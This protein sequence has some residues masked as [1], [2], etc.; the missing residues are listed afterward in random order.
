[1]ADNKGIL[2]ENTLNASL[3]KAGVQS[4]TFVGAGSDSNAPDAQ[5]TYKGKDYKVEVKLDMNVDFGQGSLDYDL[6]NE[7]WIIG[8]G[9]TESGKQMKQ[10]L[11]KIGVDKLVNKK[12][13]PKGAPRR[14]SVPLSQ[15][16]KDDVDYDYKTFKNEFVDI[17]GDAVANYY[18]SK[19]TYYIQ[20]G[21]KGLYYMGKDIAKLGVP[22]FDLKLKLRIRLK[23]G[24]SVPI[25]NYRFATAIQAVK[26]TLS[27]SD[28]DLDNMDY[29]KALAARGKK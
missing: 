8:G 15:Y 7:K 4:K 20:I 28:A 24:G 6:E 21:G 12:W 27:N 19:Q 11:E 10:F 25:Y 9:K 29:L 23:R 14:Y 5:I 3:K 1:M 17:P 16:K 22:E 26:G 13:G 18:N 2:Y